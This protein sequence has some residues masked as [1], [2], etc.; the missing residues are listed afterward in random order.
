MYARKPTT[1]RENAAS[2]AINS[3]LTRSAGSGVL[4]SITE[5]STSEI[6]PA[7]VSMP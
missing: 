6:T 7:T 4:N 5:P 2:M 3:T 1:R